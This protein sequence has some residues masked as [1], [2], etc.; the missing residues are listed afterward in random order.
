[1]MD[2]GI[3]IKNDGRIVGVAVPVRGG[4]MFF[5]SDPDLKALEATI[6]RQAEMIARQV[7]E[8]VRARPNLMVQTG[9]D[10]P[11]SRSVSEIVVGGGNVV[12]LQPRQCHTNADPEPPDAA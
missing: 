6:F 10:V 8:I 7:A 12:R 11:P 3:V 1:M 9:V 2:E 4:F 5:S